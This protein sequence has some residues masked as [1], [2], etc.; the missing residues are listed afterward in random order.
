MFLSRPSVVLDYWYQ[1]DAGYP[2]ASGSD[3]PGTIG[4]AAGLALPVLSALIAIGILTERGK[5]MAATTDPVAWMAG[6]VVIL[7]AVVFPTDLLGDLLPAVLTVA[8]MVWLTRVEASSSAARLANIN[9]IVHAR[10]VRLELRR[11]LLRDAER[12]LFASSRPRLVDGTLD[13]TELDTRRH[14]FE[15]SAGSLAT[16]APGKLRVRDSAFSSGAGYQP[17]YNAIVSTYMGILLAA[18]IIAWELIQ[19]KV[20]I[21]ED[22]LFYTLDTLRHAGRWAAYAAFFGFFYPR[23]RGRTPIVKASA[24][25]IGILPGELLWILA[26]EATTRDRVLAMVALAGQTALFSL[27]LGLFWEYRL[28]TAAD[29]SWTLLRSVRSLRSLGVP[30]T[31]VLV[32][33]ATAAA[34]VL[35]G[36][37]VEPLITPRPP[38]QTPA[39]T[40]PTTLRTP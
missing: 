6:I 7:S 28:M 27:G 38:V 34:T 17:S 33:A 35:G 20:N 10:L 31:A 16:D 39:S 29:L 1:L 2:T 11:R 19:A 15:S 4:T 14:R 25:L 13:I 36:A 37:A 21:P 9:R 24:L 18:P 32:A 5:S 40:S 22:P 23:V 30:I 8:L 12:E 26:A 3:V